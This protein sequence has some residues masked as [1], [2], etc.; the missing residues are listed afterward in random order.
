MRIELGQLVGE[1]SA[2]ARHHTGLA[3]TLQTAQGQSWSYFC[4]EVALAVQLPRVHR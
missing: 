1:E 2:I 4:T 3:A